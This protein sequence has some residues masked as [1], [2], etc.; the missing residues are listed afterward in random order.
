VRLRAAVDSAGEAV[1]A[2][3]VLAVMGALALSGFAGLLLS[4]WHQMADTD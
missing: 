4:A 1:T 2:L 3:T